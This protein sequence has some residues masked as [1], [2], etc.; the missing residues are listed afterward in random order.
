VHDQ[1]PE[2]QDGQDHQRRQ[3]LPYLDFDAPVGPVFLGV[4]AVVMR[5]SPVSGRRSM[6]RRALRTLLTHCGNGSDHARYARQ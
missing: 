6:V 4:I 3:D 1:H 2:H 5:V